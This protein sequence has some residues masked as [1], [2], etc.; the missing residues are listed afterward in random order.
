MVFTIIFERQRKETISSEKSSEKI[1]QVINEQPSL[2]AIEMA[3][4]VV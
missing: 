2:S 1:L 3:Q 4:L